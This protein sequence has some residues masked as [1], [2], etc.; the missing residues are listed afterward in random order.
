MEHQS[1]RPGGRTASPPS[2]SVASLVDA[3]LHAH[4][5]GRLDTADSLYREILALDPAH[6]RALHYFGVLHYQRGQHAAAATLMSQ[7][8]KHDRH[9][10]ACWSNRG[11]AA[12]ALGRLDEATICY[13]Q[14][15]QLQPDFADARN[16]FG[17]ALQAQGALDD[18]LEQYRLA[19]ASNPAFVDAHLNLGTA[20]GKLGRF[21]EALACYR[22]A[23]RLD[24]TSA[25]AHFNAG[26]AHNAQ[27]EHEAAVASFERALAL[28]PDYAEA[29]VNLGSAIGKRGDYA[30]AEAHYRR[31]VVL[32][33]N[34]TNLVCLGGSLGAQG[35]LD[36]EEKFYR[37]A[38]AQ[39]PGYAD[40]HQNLAWLLLKRG[41]YT[42]GWA[43]FALRW[44]KSDYDALAVAGVAEW[45]GEPLDGR[46]LLIVGEQGFG[47]H[48]QFLRY[49]RALHERGARVD[50]C[51]RE[52]LLRLIQRM[53]GVHRAF[54]GRPDAPYDFWVPMMSVPSCVGTELATIPAELPYLFADETK[55]EAW[56]SKLAASGGANRKVGLVW[57]GSPT[58]GNDRYRSMA[59]A[60]LHPLADAANVSWYPL[61]QGPAH[62][63]LAGAP[64]ALRAHDFTGELGDFEDTAALIMN[65]DLVIAVDTAVAHLAGALGKPVWLLLPANS[66]WRWLQARSDS[67]WYPGMRLFRQQVLGEWAG[68]VGDVVHA[69]QTEEQE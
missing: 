30:G 55:I 37:E 58:F 23:L 59:L 50:V 21:A 66:D 61:Q 32:Q 1:Q 53:P 67:P 7:A 8:L 44:R 42:E 3:A 11:L 63:Q 27:G 60:D 14:A 19:I 49:A 33:A 34:P 41:D 9:D 25:E 29:H 51:V 10:A 15:L 18:A 48:F 45:R 13:D 62:A 69:L 5:A 35:R 22:D 43:E 64:L 65:L 31:A 24:P 20:L 12:A 47:D 28:R 40:A 56:R 26:N 4:Q 68:V 2:S 54:A 36:E 17:V 46:R 38:L 57:A 16:N 52:P 39:D 6:A